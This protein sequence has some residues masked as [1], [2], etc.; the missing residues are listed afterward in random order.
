MISRKQGGCK[1]P[2]FIDLSCSAKKTQYL[3]GREKMGSKCYKNTG[4]ITW[5]VSVTG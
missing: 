2:N 4:S 3:S 1:L 5:V